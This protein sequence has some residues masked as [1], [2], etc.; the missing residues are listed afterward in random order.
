MFIQPLCYV[1]WLTSFIIVKFIVGS[2]RTNYRCHQGLEISSQHSITGCPTLYIHLH[3]NV[4]SCRCFV[5]CLALPSLTSQTFTCKTGRS[6]DISISS[7]VT[8]PKS[9]SKD[10][11]HDS[12]NSHVHSKLHSYLPVTQNSVFMTQQ[13]LHSICSTRTAYVPRPSHFTRECLAHEIKH[14]FVWSVATCTFI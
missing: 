11:S 3:V 2:R 13:N 1:Q 5:W 8:L 14:C 7:F 6:A 12:T 4:V 10:K 9:S